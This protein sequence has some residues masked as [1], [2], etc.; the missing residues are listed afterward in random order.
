MK[1]TLTKIAEIKSRVDSFK[2]LETKL[3]SAGPSI[4]DKIIRSQSLIEEHY[5]ADVSDLLDMV[6]T[7]LY[8][9]E[10]LEPL[11]EMPTKGYVRNGFNSVLRTLKGEYIG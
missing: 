3:M 5:Y 1:E 8:E 11:L 2:E 4:A 6:G 10:K 7:A 9:L